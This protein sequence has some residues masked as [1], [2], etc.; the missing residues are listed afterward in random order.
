MLPTPRMITDASDPLATLSAYALLFGVNPDTGRP[1]SFHG[2]EYLVQPLDDL[3]PRV[4]IM[5]GAQV[6]ATV[7]AVMR[8]LWFVDVRQAHTLYLFPTHRSALRF[9]RGRLR[10]LLE[11]APRFRMLFG[12]SPTATHLRAGHV[13]WYCHGG[14]SRVELL[15]MPVQYLTIDERDAMYESQPLGQ[16][17]WSA[18]ELA[19][20]RLAGHSRAWELNLSTPTVPGRGIAADFAR[21]DQRHFEPRCPRCRRW[22]RLDWP[23]FLRGWEGRPESAAWHCPV[24][25]GLWSQ[26]DRQAALAQGRWTADVAGADVH[27]YFVPQVLAPTQSPSRLVAAWQSAQGHVAATQVFWNS[28]L[29][30]PYRADGARLEDRYWDEALARSDFPMEDAATGGRVLGVDVGPTWLHGIIAEPRH[31]GLRLCWIGRL[32]D[33]GELERLI[34]RFQLE[35]FVIDAQPE[36]HA[37]RELALRHPAGFLCYY[38]GEGCEL[39]VNPVSRILR[40]PRTESLDALFAL[41]RRGQIWLP[42]EA[43]DELRLHLQSLVRLYRVG[44][45]GQVRA[46]Y[47]DA[48]GPD[49]FAHALNYCHLAALLAP[50]SQ[51]WLRGRAAGPLFDW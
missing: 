18:V 37:A 6:G 50:R 27:G 1:L 25:R 49:H 11:R 26:A 9:T 19:R 12:T 20:Q 14:K 5:K 16:T 33:W 42:T 40:V 22:V 8:A 41:W 4:V 36:T 31:P 15:S 3:A 24:C 43:P 17:P 7:L 10:V 46:E 47:L 39:N 34:D 23:N 28:I 32:P 13:N 38:G 45:H 51:G 30:L 35:A 44:R 21:T 48:G 29:G 2:Y